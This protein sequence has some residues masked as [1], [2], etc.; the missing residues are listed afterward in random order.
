MSLSMGQ[1]AETSVY[2]SQSQCSPTLR[3]MHKDPNFGSQFHASEHPNV[4][5][6]EQ[7][8]NVSGIEHHSI[9]GHNQCW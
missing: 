1:P 5:Y 8:Q 6:R 4:F 3:H 7:S 9:N 2:S